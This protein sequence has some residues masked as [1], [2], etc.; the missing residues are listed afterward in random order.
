V[1]EPDRATKEAHRYKEE[2]VLKDYLPDTVVGSIGL[3][4]TPIMGSGPR[5]WYNRSVVEDGFYGDR[6]AAR[7]KGWLFIAMGPKRRKAG[8]NIWPKER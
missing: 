5:S 3:G 2:I 8:S 4:P 1:E 6:S 7:Q